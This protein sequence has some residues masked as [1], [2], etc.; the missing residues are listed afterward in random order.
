[1]AFSSKQ[2]VFLAFCKFS[3]RTAFLTWGLFCLFLCSLVGSGHFRRDPVNSTVY[4]D[5]SRDSVG[6][7]NVTT[8]IASNGP[9]SAGGWVSSISIM[10]IHDPAAGN[11]SAF[12][13][14]C[15]PGMF[16]SGYQVNQAN[17]ILGMSWRCS[18]RNCG[19]PLLMLP[20]SS[21]LRRGHA[22]SEASYDLLFCGWLVFL[23]CCS[24]CSQFP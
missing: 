17:V 16:I 4:G 11:D 15:P 12:I 20:F 9:Y 6:L 19:M 7:V 22:T 1:M 13:D 5:A 14:I 10:Q 18:C 2:I 23:I 3:L 24:V 8:T 21:L